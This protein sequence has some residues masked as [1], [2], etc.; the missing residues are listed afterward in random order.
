[1][2]VSRD[3]FFAEVI[4]SFAPLFWVDPSCVLFVGILIDIFLV[5][6]LIVTIVPTHTVVRGRSVRGATNRRRRALS[7]MGLSFPFELLKSIFQSI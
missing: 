1:M 7:S 2:G 4:Y 3:S 6:L 5:H